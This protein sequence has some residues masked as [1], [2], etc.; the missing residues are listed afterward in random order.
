M[1]DAPTSTLLSGDIAT[2]TE[3]GAAVVLDVGSN[4]DRRRRRQPQF[5]HR[6]AYGFTSVTGLVAAQDQLG[7]ATTGGVTSTAN[8]VSVGGIQIATYTGGGAGGGDLVFTLRSGRHPGGGAGA[9]AR[10]HLRQ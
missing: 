4:L 5:R 1:N 2:W 8:T 3:G 10:D 6:H 7:I 9:D